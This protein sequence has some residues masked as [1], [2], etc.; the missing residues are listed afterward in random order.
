MA[1]IKKIGV[2]IS[3]ASGSMLGLEVLKGLRALNDAGDQLEIHLIVTD[4][5]KR[6]A[7][8]ELDPER[9]ST[10]YELAHLVHDDKDLAASIASGSNA[11]D[12]LVIAPCSIRSLASVAY[13]QTDRLSIRCADVMLKERRK[14]VLAVRETPLHLGHIEAMTRVTQMGGIIAP[15]VPAFYLAPQSIGEMLQQT[16]ARL[17][18]LLDLDVNPL[19][20]RWQPPEH[21]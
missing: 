2:V 14:L 8:L 6:T 10:L 4:G 11:L 21:E 17:L 15:P 19:I 18:S 1:Q 12:G 5:G 9:V 7:A 20:K 13:C 16:A 3:G